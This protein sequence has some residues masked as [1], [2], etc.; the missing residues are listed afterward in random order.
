M[1]SVIFLHDTPAHDDASQYQVWWQ[2]VWQFRRYHLDKHTLTFLTFTVTLTLIESSNPVLLF[3]SQDT[4]ATDDV[5]SDQVWLPSKKSHILDLRFGIKMSCGS[6]GIIRTNIHWH[7]EP[8]LWPWPW[9]QQSH[10]SQD[11]AAYD[12][13]LLNQVS[14]QTDQQFGRSRNSRIWIYISPCCDLDVEDS[15]PV[16]VHD[17]PSHDNITIST[18]VKNGLVVKNVSSG[19]NPNART[20]GQTGTVIQ[21]YPPPAPAISLR[22]WGGV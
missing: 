8:F 1:L 2:N 17:T 5:R 13:A 14:L 15:G 21:I 6:D 20:D 19:Q 16:F 10:F 12:A 3:F 11:T 7:F 22:G 18:L 9:T 4:L